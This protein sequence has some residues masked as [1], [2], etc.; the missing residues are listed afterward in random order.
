MK[1]LG[2][3]LQS[4]F[5]LAMVFE[6]EKTTGKDKIKKFSTCTVQLDKL[7]IMLAEL[8]NARAH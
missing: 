2:G 6:E 4:S 3:H 1:L 8:M 7:Q 5:V